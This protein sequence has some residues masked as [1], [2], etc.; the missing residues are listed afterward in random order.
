MNREQIAKEWANGYP[1]TPDGTY[2][3]S[4][5]TAISENSFLAGWDA[6]EA[7]I[8]ER[9]TALYQEGKIDSYALGL[10]FKEEQHPVDAGR[11]KA[12][13]KH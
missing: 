8:M 2:T 6:C 10:L 9:A 11:A 1:K 7:H 12:K 4:D 3:N 13:E 5:A